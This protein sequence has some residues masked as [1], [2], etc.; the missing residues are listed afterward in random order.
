MVRYF[1]EAPAA[2]AAWAVYFLSGRRPKRLVQAQLLRLWAADLNDIPLW[3][4]EE[5]Y[6]AVGDSAETAILLLPPATAASERSLQHWIEERILPLR[7]LDAIEQRDTV[8]Q[9]WQELDDAER[10]VFSK[11]ITGAFRVGVSQRLLTRAL[12][13]YSG[14]D[15]ATIAHRLMGTWSPTARFFEELVGPDTADADRSRP[16]PFFLAYPL[17]EE[18]EKLGDVAEWQVEWKWDGI[19]AQLIRRQG[20][21]FLWSRGEELV[22]PRYPE[23]AEAAEALPDGTVLDGELLAWQAGQVLP[24]AQL[25]RRIGRKTVGKKLLTDVPAALL[26]YDLLEWQAEDVRRWPLHRRRKQLEALLTRLDEPRLPLS[27]TVEAGSWAELAGRRK[28]SRE[29]LVEGFMLKRRSSPYRV[30]RRRG[31]WWKWKIDPYTIDAVLIYAQKGAGRRANLYTDYTFAVWDGDE[32]VPFAKAYSGLT[33]AEIREV[34]RFVRDNTR[35]RFGPV[36]SVRPELVFELAIESIQHSNRHKSGIAVRFPRMA[37]W[38]RDKTIADADNLET[39]R[40][41]LEGVPAD[42]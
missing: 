42:E 8:L 17:E 35:E 15:A 25:Q 22:T 19:R 3:L 24:F 4:L 7:G 28:E 32:L 1:E 13:A 26:V 38:R 41:M 30:G 23:I 16:Y 2:D 34:D 9:A 27:E 37:R 20:E 29:R 31:D 40:A 18:P 12:A 33:D 14:V 5:S 21:T 39:I 36:R 10:F 11:L 6:G